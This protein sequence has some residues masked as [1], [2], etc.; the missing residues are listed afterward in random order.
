[1]YKLV[2]ID[3]DNTLFDYNK[4]EA[5]ALENSLKDFGFNRDFNQIRQDYNEINKELWQLLEKGGITKDELSKKRFR[6]LFEKYGLDIPPKDFSQ[7]YLAYLRQSNFLMKDAQ[8][9]IQYL[10]ENYT[11]I[12]VT[13]GIKNVQFSRLEKSNIKDYNHGVVVSEDIGVSKP[14]PD[15]FVHAFKLANHKDKKS[16]IIIGDSLSSDIKGGI[17]FGIDTCW[18]NFDNSDPD[19]GLN[20]TYTI[21][22]LKEIYDIL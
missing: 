9:L 17:N 21:Y 16:A 22:Q 1:M 11:V 19:D 15:F 2:L 6:Q 5:Y 14:N 18:F 10:Y 13:N 12:I 3:A 7:K 20:P 4:A 8:E